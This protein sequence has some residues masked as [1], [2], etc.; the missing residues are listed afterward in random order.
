[1]LVVSI[2]FCIKKITKSENNNFLIVQYT[3]LVFLRNYRRVYSECE[4]RAQILR[5]YSLP[6]LDAEKISS[7]GTRTKKKR[8]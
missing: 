6:K 2:F 7:G 1:M 3:V 8:D 5:T 4:R